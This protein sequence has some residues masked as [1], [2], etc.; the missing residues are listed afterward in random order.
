MRKLTLLSGGALALTLLAAPV[1][2][3]GNSKRYAVTE[4]KALA[5]T[6]DVLVKQGYDVVRVEVVGPTQVVYYRRGNQAMG[7]KGQ[8]GEIVIRHGPIFVDTPSH[9]GHRRSRSDHRQHRL[10]G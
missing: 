5:V 9:L 8:A 3:Q 7:R 4:D 6:R 2:A 1:A 10:A